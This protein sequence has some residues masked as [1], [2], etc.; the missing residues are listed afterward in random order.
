MQWNKLY[1]KDGGMLHFL[2]DTKTPLSQKKF[3]FT[4][5]IHYLQYQISLGEGIIKFDEPFYTEN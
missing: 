4:C 3:L 5:Q 1:E 2:T